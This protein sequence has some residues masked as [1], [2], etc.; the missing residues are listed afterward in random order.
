MSL[1][2]ATLSPH[3]PGGDVRRGLINSDLALGLGVILPLPRGHYDVV[4]GLGAWGN[5]HGVPGW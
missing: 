4:H 5:P 3:P 2:G 1:V